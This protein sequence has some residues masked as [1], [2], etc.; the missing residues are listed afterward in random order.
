MQ[1]R[2]VHSNS[3]ATLLFLFPKSEYSYDYNSNTIVR[4][5]HHNLFFRQ[6]RSSISLDC[7]V[8]WYYAFQS[9]LKYYLV[10]SLE[11]HVGATLQQISTFFKLVEKRNPSISTQFLFRYKEPHMLYIVQELCR[12]KN[13]SPNFC[14]VAILVA[15]ETNNL[16][17][18]VQSLVRA[19]QDSLCPFYTMVD[20]TLSKWSPISFTGK[21]DYIQLK[22]QTNSSPQEQSILLPQCKILY[23]DNIRDLESLH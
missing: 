19:Q 21:V 7:S 1:G 9:S 17:Q 4:I 3:I 16:Q 8:N 6:I 2:L 12:Q 14:F 22:V 23:I 18:L 10:Y 11:P 20:I 15:D 13:W 5:T